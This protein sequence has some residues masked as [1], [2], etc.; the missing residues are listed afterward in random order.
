MKPLA[1]A[2]LRVAAVSVGAFI[3]V[4]IA[5]PG[6][7]LGAGIVVASFAATAVASLAQP[8]Q[9]TGYR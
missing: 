6:F 1:L 7:W 8:P 4:S 2:L 5:Q 3:I 9:K